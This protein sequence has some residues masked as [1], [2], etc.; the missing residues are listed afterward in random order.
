[1][2]DL[3]EILDCFFDPEKKPVQPKPRYFPRRRFNSRTKRGKDERDKNGH[4]N[5]ESR[6][7]GQSGEQ[8]TDEQQEQQQTEGSSQPDTVVSA[9]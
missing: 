6:N 3:L 8:R 2:S 9:V 1:M 4:R 7:V 5:S